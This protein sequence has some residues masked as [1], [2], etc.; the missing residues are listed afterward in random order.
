MFPSHDRYRV[1]R[2]VDA[3]DGNG[4]AVRTVGEIVFDSFNT[5]D[6]V[7][8]LVRSQTRFAMVPGNVNRTAQSTGTF[9]ES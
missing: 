4:K 3:L 7:T 1:F 8:E 6:P 5:K 2:G 9:S